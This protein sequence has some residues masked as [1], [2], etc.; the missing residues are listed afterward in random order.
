MAVE[1]LFLAAVHNMRVSESLGRGIVISD[2]MYLS[3]DRTILKKI[4]NR[5]TVEIIGK[6]EA[7]F[8]LNAPLFVHGKWIEEK[9]LSEIS[10]LPYLNIKMRQMYAFY[11]SLWT[12]RD[13][14]VNSETVFLIEREGARPERVSVNGMAHRY[15]RFDSKIIEEY[16]SR[17]E[18][19]LTRDMFSAR[20][21]ALE[22]SRIT[23]EIELEYAKKS[24]RIGRAFKFL[25]AARTASSMMLKVAYQ[26]SFLEA[27]FCTDSGEVS[28]KM[29]ER[30]AIFLGETLEERDDIYRFLKKSYGI[31]S[32]VIHGSAVS[33]DV[34]GLVGTC[35]ALDETVR[36]IMNR[37]LSNTNEWNLFM[38]VDREAFDQ[39][40]LTRLLA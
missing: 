30:V 38:K 26:C 23:P 20:I 12:L 27:M 2:N 19:Q 25:F 4:L 11:D 5:S 8:L 24:G 18:I 21:R 1:I 29:A 14:C 6:M 32:R 40:F 39:H 34:E 35:V 37:V 31:R 15:D 10:P 33:G 9:A 16:F 13:N 36:K 3:D 22:E 7:D 28:H 17:K